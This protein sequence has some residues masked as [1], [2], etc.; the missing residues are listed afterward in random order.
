MEKF[1]DFKVSAKKMMKE[2][3]EKTSETAFNAAV[4]VSRN[5]EVV[6]LGIPLLIAATRTGQSL[7]VSR[8]MKEEYKR[9]DRSFYDNRTQV[10]WELRRKM[11]NAEKAKVIELRDRVGTYEALKS[12]RLI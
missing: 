9:A 5:K 1:E 6:T 3:K 12:L 10:R 8:R 2:V 11:T 7:I 4:W